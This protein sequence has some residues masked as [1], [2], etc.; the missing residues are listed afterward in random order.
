MEGRNPITENPRFPGRWEDKDREAKECTNTTDYFE[1]ARFGLHQGF[2]NTLTTSHQFSLSPPGE[3]QHND[4]ETPPSSYTFGAIYNFTSKLALTS[5]VDFGPGRSFSRVFWAPSN[6][7]QFV[8][9]F[10][11]NGS[12]AT[13]VLDADYFGDDKSV[14]LKLDTRGSLAVNYMQTVHKGWAAGTEFAHFPQQGTTAAAAI[15]YSSQTRIENTPIHSTAVAVST[16]G[17]ISASYYRHI[18]KKF[19]FSTEY[20][21]SG[22][23]EDAWAAGF[24]AT[25]RSSRL[26]A[27][28]DHNYRVSA[29]AEEELMDI[30][31]LGFCA[32]FDY[33]DE[34]YKLGVQAMMSA[35]RRDD[36]QIH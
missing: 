1:G 6:R 4:A 12:Q 16:Q 33:K 34:K 7:F 15:K 26:R 36:P 8:P 24:L 30:G 32:D 10:Q 23:G 25:F 28:I 14:G 27:R 19:L 29:L 17:V 18:G 5:Q 31:R 20:N 9:A 3:A 13:A 2:S 11:S 22:Q 21:S 35:E